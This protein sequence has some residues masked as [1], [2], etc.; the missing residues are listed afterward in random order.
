MAHFSGNDTTFS[1]KI[2]PLL[3]RYQDYLEALY[4]GGISLPVF[5]FMMCFRGL[6]ELSIGKHSREREFRADRI[7][8]ETTSSAATAGALLRIIAYSKYRNSIEQDLFDQ[9]QEHTSVDIYQQLDRGFH[10]FAVS[11]ASNDD[12]GE[13]ATAHPFDSHPP[14]VERL[15]AVDFELTESSAH[16][17]LSTPGDGLWFHRI[18]NSTELEQK[19][20]N[21]YEERFRE[22]HTQLLAYRYLPSTEEERALV[23]KFF[24]EVTHNGKLGAAVLDCEQINFEQWNSEVR[25]DEMTSVQVDDNVLEIEFER[26]G[27]S[28]AQRIKLAKMHDKGAALLETVGHY[29]GRYQA[30]EEYLKNQNQDSVEEDVA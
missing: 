9:D 11:F 13:F 8:T 30:A 4:G 5:Y 14:L 6:F 26:D 16:D 27:E 2:S 17:I 1:K 25:F 21:E 28:Y 29:F 12:I 22:F 20:W 3:V 18:N 24:P 19:Q 23:E 7:A 10:E 15:R